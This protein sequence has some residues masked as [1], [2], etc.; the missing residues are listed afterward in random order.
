MT[1]MDM[2]QTANTIFSE[3]AGMP[4]LRNPLCGGLRKENLLKRLTKRIIRW[5]QD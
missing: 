2:N 5:A 1:I 4:E 3:D